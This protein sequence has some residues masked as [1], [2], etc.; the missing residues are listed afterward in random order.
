MFGHRL[1]RWPDIGQKP[2]QCLMFNGMYTGKA[3]IA[4][5]EI[6]AT[7]TNIINENDNQLIR[8]ITLD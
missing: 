4:Q 8:Y 7:R 5:G 3:S 6:M 1:R 2:A